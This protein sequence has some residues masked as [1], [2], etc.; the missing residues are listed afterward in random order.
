MY[1]YRQERMAYGRRR[2]R[3][4]MRSARNVIQSYKKV[5]N[6]A[7]A[8]HA[9]STQIANVL[10][11]GVDSVAAGQTGP[12]DA[13]I[14]TGAIVTEIEIQYSVTNLVSVSAFLHLTIQRVHFGQGA[15][16]GNA[17]GGNAQRNQVHYQCMKSLGQN[18]NNNYVFKFKVPKKFQ[19]VRESDTWIFST[20]CDQIWTDSIQVIYKFYR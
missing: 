15:I 2:K 13:N 3:S 12:T 4:T 8:S 9:A 17:V 14:P 10:T 5:L 7:P 20:L 1:R 16:A 18:Q 19:R 6:F 11:N